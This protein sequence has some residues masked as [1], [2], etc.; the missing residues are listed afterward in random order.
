VVTNIAV[1]WGVTSCSLVETLVKLGQTTRNYILKTV[2]LMVISDV[3]PYHFTIFCYTNDGSSRHLR[4]DGKC[5][6]DYRG[7]QHRDMFDHY[8][9]HTGSGTRK[10]TTEATWEQSCRNAKPTSHFVANNT[11]L[12]VLSFTISHRY[13]M[14]NITTLHISLITPALLSYFITHTTN[15]IAVFWTYLQPPLTLVLLPHSTK[16]E[17]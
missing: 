7:S 12:T 6:P 16:L 15:S 10:K 5:L 1:F 11:Q 2:K 14:H 4:N 17:L 8:C 13:D 3:I 9:C